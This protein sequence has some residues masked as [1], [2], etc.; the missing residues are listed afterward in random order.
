MADI[1]RQLTIKAP[2]KKIYGLIA[3]KKGIR[4]WLTKEDGW[5]ITG[6]EK[7]GDTLLFIFSENHHEMKISKLDP[8]KEIKWECTVGHP[9]WVGTTVDFTIEVKE[10]KCILHFAQEGW[11]SK[12]KF[13]EQ[14]NEVWAGNIAD[15]KKLAEG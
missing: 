7:P 13:F 4:E 14:C 8:Q 3:T 6:E 12:T 9:E 10:D 2:A 5:K 11:A 1:K 15:I